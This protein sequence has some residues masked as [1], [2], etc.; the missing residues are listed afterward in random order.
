MIREQ[1]LI[2]GKV[3]GV[4][5]RPFVYKLATKLNLGG[6]IRND[7]SG[8]EIQIEGEKSQVEIFN[9]KLLN[10]LPPLASIDE[11]KKSIIDMCHTG[12]FEIIQSKYET[13]TSKI[14]SVPPDV[15]IC[16]ECKSDILNKF[17]YYNYFATSCTNCGP[18]YS[19]IQTVPY[20]RINTSFKD[21]VLCK[22]CKKDYENPLDRRYHAQTTVCKECGPKLVLSA[23]CE[24]SSE[25]E[26]I[27]ENIATLIKQGKIGAIKG[28]GGFHLVCDATND[29]VIERLRKF[30]N[31]PSKPF[32][33]MCNNLERGHY[34]SLKYFL[35]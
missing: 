12:Q 34:L 18:R 3:Q 2:K 20:D 21:F 29:E 8:V 24:V 22:S 5:F 35:S 27:Y 4:G 14:A 9:Q 6:F 1:L 11:I 28:I 32:A 16:N 33:L 30:K 26:E 13:S 15:R 10:S 31:R 19:I 23:K 7:L 17:K 25:K